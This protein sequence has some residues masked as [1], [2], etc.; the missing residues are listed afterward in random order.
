L[1]RETVALE[2]AANPRFLR[3]PAARDHANLPDLQQ[4]FAAI[5]NCFDI[6][7]SRRAH[8]GAIGGALKLAPS[9]SRIAAQAMAVRSSQ[10][11]AMIWTP[12]GNPSA[13]SIAGATAA[14]KPQWRGKPTA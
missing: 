9:A 4:A 1:N 7:P 11:A 13:P 14:G 2:Q 8:G 12:R 10:L 5:G 6:S 3:L